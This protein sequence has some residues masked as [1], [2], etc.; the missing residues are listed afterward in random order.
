MDEN[1]SNHTPAKRPSFASRVAARRRQKKV[2]W[3]DRRVLL[4][5]ARA[6]VVRANVQLRQAIERLNYV[7][8][9]EDGLC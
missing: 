9:S 3:R 6:E 7:I 2:S 1:S 4:S 5:K 8:D